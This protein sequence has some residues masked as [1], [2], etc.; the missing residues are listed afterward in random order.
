MPIVIVPGIVAPGFVN[1]YLFAPFR[2]R[3]LRLIF[4]NVLK[5]QSRNDHVGG[6]TTD[7]PNIIPERGPFIDR[8]VMVSVDKPAFKPIRRGV[9]LQMV[10]SGR[11]PEVMRV[12]DGLESPHQST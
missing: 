4:V 9:N 6:K 12:V 2:L 8:Q 3:P 10:S 7:R 11:N 5:A 1:E